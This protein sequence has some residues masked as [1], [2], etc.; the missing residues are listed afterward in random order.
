MEETLLRYVETQ[1][2]YYI[3]GKKISRYFLFP[4]NCNPYF[5]EHGDI[6]SSLL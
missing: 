5:S 1:H 6:Y 4:V 3:C 2:Y